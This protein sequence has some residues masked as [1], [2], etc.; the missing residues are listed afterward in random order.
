MAVK[1]KITANKE[2]II[3][4]LIEERNQQ[5]A[6]AVNAKNIKAKEHFRGVAEGI[7]FAICMLRD[8]DQA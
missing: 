1:R 8:W 7:E 6:S 5:K 3:N 4:A 2:S